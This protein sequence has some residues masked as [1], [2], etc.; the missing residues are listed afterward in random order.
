MVSQIS[1][2]LLDPSWRKA[3]WRTALTLYAAILIMGSV[4]GARAEI[5]N[6]ASG[7]VLHSLA[8]AILTLLLFTGSLGTPRARAVKAV[9][10]IMAMGAIDELIQSQLPY[11]HG[12]VS[13]WLVDVNAAVI[14]SALLW[15][16]LPAPSARP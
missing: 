4:P 9:L 5:G 6:V 16:F 12:A 13:D 7:L 15:A 11:R 8:Y 2:L 10:C 1:S 3:R 14:T